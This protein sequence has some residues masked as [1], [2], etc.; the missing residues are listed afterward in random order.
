MPVLFAWRGTV[1]YL[2]ACAWVSTRS[3]STDS[4]FFHNCFLSVS[5][6]TQL[7]C[8]MLSLR[9][10]RYPFHFKGTFFKS[11]SLQVL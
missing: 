8:A 2:R 6:S 10:W 4:Y 11:C 7:V 1:V 9:C 3:C 5:Y